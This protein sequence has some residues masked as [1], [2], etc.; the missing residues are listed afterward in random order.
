V[1]LVVFDLDRT[2][3]WHDTLLPY[4]AGFLGRRPL[5]RLRIAAA[6]P[7][8]AVQLAGGI[9]RGALKATLLRHTLRGCTRTQIDDWNARWVPEL[10]ARGTR[11]QAL[12]A[13]ESH[14]RAGDHLVLMS[15]SPDLY[16]PAI[17][18][19][20]GFA[21]TVSTGVRWVEERLDGALTTANRRGEEKARCLLELKGRHPSLRVV[22]YGNAASD[23]PHL[24]LV[25]EPRLVN[26][27]RA[28]VRAAARIGIAPYAQWR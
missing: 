15:A 10:V 19:R 2:I 23:L 7:A 24:M 25:D 8:L 6:L 11:A 5:Q 4:V 20:L 14:R 22:G 1:Q 21:E 13:I 12:T 26:A 9:D 27:S 16:V 18:A 3:T 17:G 28:T